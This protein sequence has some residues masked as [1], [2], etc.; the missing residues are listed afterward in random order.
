MPEPEY[1]RRQYVVGLGRGEAS[2]GEEVVLKVEMTS[3][4]RMDKL[5]LGED[6]SC[7]VILRISVEGEDVPI[8]SDVSAAA[9]EALGGLPVRYEI[10]TCQKIEVVLRNVSDG[11]AK[12]V[13]GVMGTVL[14]KNPKWSSNG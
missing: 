9:V 11:R 1:M 13:G 2:A 7:F 3:D 12:I 10:K 14:T 4:F 5:V 6:T 8:V